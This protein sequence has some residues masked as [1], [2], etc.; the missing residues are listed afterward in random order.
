MWK[1]NIIVNNSQIIAKEEN[2]SF[3]WV[4]HHQPTTLGDVSTTLKAYPVKGT[5]YSQL[6]TNLFLIT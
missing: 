1:N 4:R 2:L 6:L 3:C 5:L